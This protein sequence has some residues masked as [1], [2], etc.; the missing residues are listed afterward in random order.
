MGSQIAF[1]LMHSASFVPRTVYLCEQQK[2]AQTQSANSTKTPRAETSL[3]PFKYESL[4]STD[5]PLRRVLLYLHTE[6]AL[7][8]FVVVA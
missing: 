8:I 7:S 4:L 6:Q 3:P 2:P 5:V 1:R